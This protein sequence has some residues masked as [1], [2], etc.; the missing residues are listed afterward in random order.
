MDTVHIF[1]EE[2]EF[3]AVVSQVIRMEGGGVNRGRS[4]TRCTPF[5]APVSTRP[6]DI[7]DVM[8]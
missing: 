1:C 4:R 6:R 5:R 8:S 2:N 7:R 3:S